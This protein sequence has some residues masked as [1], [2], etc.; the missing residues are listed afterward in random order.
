MTRGRQSWQSIVRKPLLRA[1]AVANRDLLSLSA[2]FV[3]CNSDLDHQHK[4]AYDLF[5]PHGRA[6]HKRTS[7]GWV[8][9]VYI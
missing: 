9:Q 5:V 6:S 1:G 7:D 8:S 4:D 2:K 3:F